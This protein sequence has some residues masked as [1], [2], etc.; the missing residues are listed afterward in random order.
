MSTH[1]IEQIE[2]R[3]AHKEKPDAEQTVMIYVPTSDEPVWFGW[4]DGASLWYDVSGAVI[5]GKA[6]VTHWAP[7]PEGPR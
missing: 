3:D 7:M 2:W 4:F 6:S 5:G 1:T